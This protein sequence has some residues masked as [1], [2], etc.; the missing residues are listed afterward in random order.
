MTTLTKAAPQKTARSSAPAIPGWTSILTHVEPHGVG[1]ERLSAA[2]SLARRCDATLIGLGAELM[3]PVGY[4]DPYGA[5]DGMFLTALREQ[6]VTD[7]AH[8]ETTFKKQATGVKSEWRSV[9]DRPAQA[10]ARV[11][12]SADLIV[13]GGKPPESASAYRTADPAEIALLSGRPVLVTPPHGGPLRAEAVIVAWK[14]TREARRAIADALPILKVAE[15]V[16]VVEIYPEGELADAEFHTADVAAALRRHGVKARGRAVF[17]PD[18][19][20][21]AVLNGQARL[22]DADLI[23]AGCYGHSRMNEWFFGGA[24]RDLLQNPDRYVLVSH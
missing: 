15:E 11:A 24:T 2:I 3:E 23:V 7:L 4:A 18:I 21:G 5:T 10:L 16:H 1:A 13:A 8:A 19:E 12:R 17:A 20:V 6:V 9:E 22:I 14:D